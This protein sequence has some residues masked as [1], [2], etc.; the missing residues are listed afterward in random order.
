MVNK[1]YSKQDGGH[2]SL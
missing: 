1:R 2:R